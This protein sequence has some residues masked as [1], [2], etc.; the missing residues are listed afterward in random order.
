M[1]IIFSLNIFNIKLSISA[2]QSVGERI[3][4]R[5][6]SKT[7]MFSL[8][9]Q[10]IKCLKMTM[11]DEHRSISVIKPF[12][13]NI[14]FLIL[15]LSKCGLYLQKWIYHKIPWELK[16]WWP[17]YNNKW[18]YSLYF[19]L[20]FNKIGAALSVQRLQIAAHEWR[21]LQYCSNFSKEGQ[22]NVSVRETSEEKDNCF[23]ITQKFFD[24]VFLF[25]LVKESQH[26]QSLMY[27]SG[28]L[29]M[30]IISLNELGSHFQICLQHTAE[31]CRCK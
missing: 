11:I 1:M 4:F 15:L 3:Y 5:W 21:Q 9:W 10:I 12:P 20:F 26:P 7:W 23:K 18:I 30:M 13:S 29:W 31:L 17:F 28:G 16:V 22:H 25:E 19:L 24:L 14:P 8:S 27:E 2:S 6:C